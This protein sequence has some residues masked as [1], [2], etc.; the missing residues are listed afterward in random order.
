MAPNNT[1]FQMTTYRVTPTEVDRFLAAADA[2]R[3]L[4]RKCGCTRY[5]I[6]RNPDDPEMF[7]ELAYLP[8]LHALSEFE[9]LK[10]R[11]QGGFVKPISTVFPPELDVCRLSRADNPN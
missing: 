5:A 10:Q 4:A 8:D 11:L 7:F 9:G 1:I 6:Y 2:T 3:T